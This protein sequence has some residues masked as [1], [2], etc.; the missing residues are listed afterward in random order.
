MHLGR[1][2]V[3]HIAVKLFSVR[4]DFFVI[5]AE[6]LFYFRRLLLK[7]SNLFFTTGRHLL[8]YAMLFLVHLNMIFNQRLELALD[9]LL[10]LLQITYFTAPF[11][12][13]IGRHFATIYGKKA[14]TQKSLLITH[15]QYIS[16]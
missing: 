10:P 12:G 8:L 15:Q 6:P 14:A 4:A 13:S 16:E 9:L 1:I 7:P 3:G 2:V 5:F 11:L